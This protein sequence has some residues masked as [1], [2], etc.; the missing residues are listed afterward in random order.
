MSKSAHSINFMIMLALVLVP[1]QLFGV[2]EPVNTIDQAVSYLNSNRFEEA[3]QVC[4]S[5]LDQHPD[6]DEML[7]AEKV[8]IKVYIGRDQ[9][10]EADA[11]YQK[12]CVDFGENPKIAAAIC[13]I[14]HY[15]RKVQKYDKCKTMYQYILDNRSDHNQA[16]WA[17]AGVA[18]SNI[19]LGDDDAAAAAT[20]KLIADYTEHEFQPNGLCEVAD[21]YRVEGKYQESI[22]LYQIILNNWP[23]HKRA[24]WAQA[25]LTMSYLRLEEGLKTLEGIEKLLSEY[26]DHPALGQAVCNIA[27]YYRETGQYAKAKPLYEHVLI[28]WPEVSNV[29]WARA[30]LAMTD[31]AIGNDSAAET[32][33]EKLL[34]DFAGHP[35]LSAALSDVGL[36]YYKRAIAAGTSDLTVEADADIGKAISLWQMNTDETIDAKHQYLAHYYSGVAYQHMGDYEKA[37]VN[38]EQ[39]LNVGYEHE[40]KWHALAMVAECYDML[41]KQSKVS[42]EA[43]QIKI[44]ESYR[45][46][47]RDYPDSPVANVAANWLESHSVSIDN[48]S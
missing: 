18:I 10:A 22:P 6:M 13:D 24:M 1:T 29:I 34:A 33:K 26:S 27:H 44:E 12:L 28:K 32:G 23:N 17:Q 16:M 8:L 38:Y 9:Q 21:H 41:R 19:R 5:I 45:R 30:C 4:K 15:Y 43:A 11:A 39:S 48:P 3:E 47:V 40:R 46:L 31:V 2:T 36:A 37:A 25:G 7:K 42:E 14:G 35:E 20:A